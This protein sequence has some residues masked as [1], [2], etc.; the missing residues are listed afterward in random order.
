MSPPRVLSVIHAPHLGGPQR[1]NLALARQFAADGRAALT[2]AL[3]AGPAAQA[4]RTA[5]VAVEAVPLG[6]LRATGDPL[7]QLRYLAGW[8]GDVARLTA[9]IRDTRADV[10][11]LNGLANPQAALAARRAGVGLVWQLLDSR[12]PPALVRLLRPVVRAWADCVMTTGLD[13]AADQL[14]LDP[15]APDGPLAGRIVPFA[16]PVDAERFR[17][18]PMVR[19]AARAELGVGDRPVVGMIANLT[20][21]KGHD[22]F[23]DAAAILRRTRPDI[24]FVWLGAR[25]AGQADH[26]DRLLRR[27]RRLG[28]GDLIVRAP[29]DRVGV[30]AQAFDVAWLTSPARSE[31]IPTAAG[32]A[33]ALALPLV[34]FR[35]GAVDALVTSGR[36]GLLHPV[37][38]VAGLARDTASLLAD[39]GRR[40]AIGTAAR[41][42]AQR[43]CDPGRCADAHA[44]AFEIARAGRAE[45]DPVDAGTAPRA[46]AADG[47]PHASSARF[48]QLRENSAVSA[49]PVADQ[50]DR[51][52]GVAAQTH[53]E[54]EKRA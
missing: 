22:A 8:P 25:F 49:V 51:R 14:R 40:A 43:I 30:L 1:R 37:G 39:P 31:G 26:A 48:N 23:L 9:L 12:T 11:L 41:R 16:P 28:L 35:V 33:M 17:P 29:G 54:A 45:S 3:P 13:L 18:D 36:S 15:E 21:Q 7:R 32:E 20:P 42:A 47:A 4:L 38:D 27:A 2:V 10:V 50:E 24:A 19:A 34:G 5:G 52:G 6:R 44:R 53:A 46:T